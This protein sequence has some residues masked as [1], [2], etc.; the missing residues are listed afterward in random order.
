MTRRTLIE[1]ELVIT[2][3]DAEATAIVS[4]TS[5]VEKRRLERLG[6]PLVVDGRYRDGAEASWSATVPKQAI[7]FRRLVDGR[8]PPPGWASEGPTL[9]VCAI[10]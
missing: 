1:R 2:Y 4:T 7:R 9:P 8:Y 6:Y 5:P 3:N 10:N